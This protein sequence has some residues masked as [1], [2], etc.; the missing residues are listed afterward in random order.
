MDQITENIDVNR[1]FI[2]MIET[3]IK[4]KY[5]KKLDELF[6]RLQKDIDRKYLK[7]TS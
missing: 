3:A 1:K 7:K 4:P 2:Q 5:D 6:S